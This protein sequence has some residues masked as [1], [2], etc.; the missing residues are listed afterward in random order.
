VARTTSSVPGGEQPE[1]PPWRA[2]LLLAED[3]AP[4]DVPDEAAPRV[5]PPP[6]VRRRVE[7]DDPRPLPPAN[8][9]R[10][11]RSER[12]AADQLASTADREPDLRDVPDEPEPTVA[13]DERRRDPQQAPVARRP[14]A[15]PRP[16][17]R[18]AEQAQ[19]LPDAPSPDAWPP[20]PPEADA[21][22]FERLTG[23][24]DSWPE[25]P[26]DEPIPTAPDAP[27]WRRPRRL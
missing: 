8:E 3:P 18:P 24:P 17:A 1:L 11:E 21:H 26:P 12:V 2:E 16:S 19:A 14:E 4:E 10:V 5:T 13:A 7:R 23:S 22:L 27:S 9:S 25:L 6:A 15:Q 20:L